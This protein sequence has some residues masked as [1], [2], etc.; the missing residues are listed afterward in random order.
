MKI[1]FLALLAFFAL[2]PTHAELNTQPA[3]T[4]QSVEYSDGE[5]TMKGFLAAPAQEGTY[6][7]ILVVHE[8]WGH[9]AY[10]QERAKLLAK[11]GFVALAVDM[12]GEG[13]QA[14]HPKDAGSF[15]MAVLDNAEVAEKR[16]RAA[17]TFL[18]SQPNVSKDLPSALGYCFGG[19]VVLNMAR[20]QVPLKA[21]FSYHGSLQPIVPNKG[22]SE[23]A[24]FVFHAGN[25]RLV[26]PGQ[27][28]NFMKEMLENHARL[29]FINY[30][31]V[32]HSFTNPAAN[33]FKDAFNLPLDYNEA[34]DK[35]SWQR[36]LAELQKL[37]VLQ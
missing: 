25:D 29:T 8:W 12:Y 23:T 20:A 14:Q 22:M 35:D 34:A 10:A 21:V 37:Y 18:Q 19:A 26:P 28:A 3:I 24:I 32:E 4:T 33:H 6:P 36:T 15:A 1:I 13:K 7:G 31:H 5:I 11:E 27:V 2:V 17:L 9:N 30:P 16:F